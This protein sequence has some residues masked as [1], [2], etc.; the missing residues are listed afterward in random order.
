MPGKISDSL[1]SLVRGQ[2]VEREMDAELRFHLEMEIENNLR[3][4]MSPREA[5]RAAMNSFGGFQQV[6]EECR[7]VRR[8]RFLDE[9]SQDLRFGVRLLARNRGFTILAV[10]TLALG[11]GANSAIFSVIYG[12][13]LRPLPYAGGDRLVLIHQQAPLAQVDDMGFSVKEVLDYRNQNQ[14]LDGVVEH[15]TMGFILLGRKEA[16]RVQTGVVSA[17][18]FD[19]LGVKPLLGRTFVSHDD[20]RG[21]DAVLVLS[22]EYWQKSHGGDPGIIGRTF[23]MNDRVHTVIGVLP[24]IPQYPQEEDVYMPTSACPTRSSEQFCDNRTARMM[25]VFGRLKPGVPL[26]QAKADV[27]VIASRLREEYPDAYPANRGYQATLAPLRE[28]LTRQ[29]RP[30]FLVLL[31]TAALVLLIAC[32]NVANLTLARLMRREREMALRSALGAGSARLVRQLMTETTLLSLAGGTLGVLLAAWGLNLLVSFASRFTT[33]AGEIKIDTSVLLFTLGISLATG[34][35]LGLVP[36]VSSRKNLSSALKDGGGER[37]TAGIGRQRVRNLLVV[38]QIGV[39]FMLL[40]GAGLMLRSLMKLQQV[41]PGFNPQRVVAMSISHNWS[42][43]TTRDQL[44][45]LDQRLLEAIKSRPG[46]LAASLASNYP[47]NPRGIT[48]GPFTRNFTIEGRPLSDREPAP[49]ADIRLISP[50]YFETL[51]IPRLEGRAFADTDNEKAPEVALVNQ[52]ISR[53]RWGDESP[54]G[55]RISLDGG[56]SWVEIVGVVGDVRVYG[57]D[58]PPTD[59]LYLPL[60]QRPGAG[61]LLVRTATDPIVFSRV[62]RETVHEVEPETAITNVLTLEDARKESMASPRLTATLIALFAI[63]ALVITAAGIAGVMALTI[64][65]RTH[66]MGIR[67]AL[68]ASAGSV[69]RLVMRQGMGLVIAGLALGVVGAIAASR[70]MKALLFA[71]APTDVVTFVAVSAVLLVVAAGACYLP[72]HRVTSIDPMKALRTE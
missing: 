54:V 46:V 3:K 22:Y 69:L 60:A 10:L 72:A 17:N 64:S 66:E 71:I 29:A 5:H 31:G 35:V 48:F 55:K 21:A 36:M 27:S 39:S 50:D 45:G 51:G 65:Q 15:H 40:I 26:D 38:A 67:M 7:D 25:N 34:I 58:H 12:V 42:K 24:P 6:K 56:D 47:L 61:N 63:I 4:G 57:L 53:H 20:E 23:R 70:V 62:M 1:R 13:L 41:N 33:R 19:V 52:S 68:G 16:E 18:F 43:Y 44:R 32:A 9:L 59:E 37:S 30:T 14:T 49:Q 2:R 8:F 28:E 11:I